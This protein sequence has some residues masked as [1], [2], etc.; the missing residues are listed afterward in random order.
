MKITAT[1]RE[2]ILRRKAEYDAKRAAYEADHEERSRRYREAQYALTDPIKEKLTAELSKF[3]ALSFDVS[4]DFMF[5]DHPR[6]RI[7]CNEHN[8]FDDNVALSWSYNVELT[9]AGEVEKETSSWSGMK[10]TTS[11]QLESLKQSVAALEYLLGVNWAELLNVTRPAYRDFQEGALEAPPR[12][13]FNTEL[14]LAELEEAVGKNV[15][16]EVPNWEGSG[17][18][19]SSVYIQIEKET[20]SQYIVHVAHP[21][22]VEGEDDI[23]EALKGTGF[24]YPVRVRK[25][26]LLPLKSPLK[27]IEY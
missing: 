10:A 1:K 9:D 5:N 4:S 22:W 11:E 13:D 25:S 14:A 18:R 19:G 3:P 6:V 16:V 27:T 8:K 24:K 20:P 17:L 7:L 21:R 2:D 12:E 15:L 23:N 26:T